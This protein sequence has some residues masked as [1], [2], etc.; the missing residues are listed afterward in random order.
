ML[1]AREFKGLQVTEL[2]SS[3]DAMIRDLASI[4]QHFIYENI[5]HPWY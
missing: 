2:L 3:N 5:G 4:S 1:I